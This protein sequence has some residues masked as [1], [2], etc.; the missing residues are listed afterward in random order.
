MEIA[1][2]APNI[3][4]APKRSMLC[5]TLY[6]DGQGCQFKTTF[7]AMSALEAYLQEE[8]S[9]LVDVGTY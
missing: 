1:L 3:S 7:T 5:K 4:T 8:H 6:L 2:V 9:I